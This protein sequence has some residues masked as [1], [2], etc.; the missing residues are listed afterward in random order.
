MSQKLGHCFDAQ[1]SMTSAKMREPTP[2]MM[3]PTEKQK[4][5]VSNFQK[6]YELQDFL[7]L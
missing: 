4:L 3:S 6:K 5:N 2:I 1:G 7:H